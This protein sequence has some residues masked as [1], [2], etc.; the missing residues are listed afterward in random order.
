MVKIDFK[1]KTL[2]DESETRKFSSPWFYLASKLS[3]RTSNQKLPN[4]TEFPFPTTAP[5]ARP[6][7][8]KVQEV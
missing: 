6:P 7:L 5:P 8:S 3:Q 2:K 1:P 4:F